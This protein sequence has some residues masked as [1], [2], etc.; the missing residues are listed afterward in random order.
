MQG[1]AQKETRGGKGDIMRALR[2]YILKTLQVYCTK[3]MCGPLYP[4]QLLQPIRHLSE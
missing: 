2:A 1:R 3:D 4:L